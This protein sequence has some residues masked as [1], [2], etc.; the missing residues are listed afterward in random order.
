MIQYFYQ[1]YYTLW[2]NGYG[3][4]YQCDTRPFYLHVRFNTSISYITLC[5][6]MVMVSDISVTPVHS[7]YM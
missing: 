7:T 6:I 2:H 1:L 3:V 4:R 5:G